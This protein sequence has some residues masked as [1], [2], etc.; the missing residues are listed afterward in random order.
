MGVHAARWSRGA[1]AAA[2]AVVVLP[3]FPVLP[4]SAVEAG[5]A[6]S[7][8]SSAGDV[9]R[10]AGS[11]LTRASSTGTYSMRCAGSSR[12]A[13]S[14]QDLLRGAPAPTCWL[15]DAGAPDPD[16][17]TP[18]TLAGGGPDEPATT[19]A[20][21]PAVRLLSTPVTASPTASPDPTGTPTPTP[22]APPT[23]P[24][25][26]TGTPTPTPTA[27][28]TA[29]PETTETPTPT[30]TPSPTPEEFQQIT[31]TPPPDP[32]SGVP[33][34]D[35][36][37]TP[38]TVVVFRD[39]PDRCPFWSELTAGQ[40]AYV[41]LARERRGRIHTLGVLTSPSTTPRVGQ[42]I[43]FSRGEP[44][45]PRELVSGDVRMRAVMEE[46]VVEP[47]EEPGTTVRC[48]GRGDRLAAGATVRSGP[49][50]C[51]YTYRSTSAGRTHAGTPDN[52]TVRATE[53]WRIEVSR[54]A[55]TTWETL[56][57][58]ELET[59]TGLRVTEVQTLVV[60]LTS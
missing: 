41:E 4:A 58:V 7:L 42:T 10:T 22:T 50:L 1:V 15:Q 23:A 12:R 51:S 49:G 54:D 32:D 38:S 48:T 40:Q 57:V 34:W 33:S 39:A 43:A 47:G 44:E 37:F 3:L 6:R 27:S 16:S 55:G 2:L 31:I 9:Q 5:A 18:L 52:F 28:P 53:V 11:C 13:G 21:T 29:L 20:T 14:F 59:R 35:I 19:A 46:L 45:E 26:P 8:A 17:L 36:E 60:P 56:Q 30:P 24:P 25:D